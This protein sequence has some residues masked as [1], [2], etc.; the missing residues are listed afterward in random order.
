MDSSRG[1][2]QTSPQG[3][4]KISKIKSPF[5]PQDNPIIAG[6][7]VQTAFEKTQGQINNLAKSQVSLGNWNALTN[8]PTLPLTPTNPTYNS[9]EYYN[10]S[11]SGIFNGVQ[12]T[13][14][15]KIV[16]STN[17]A[18]NTLF[19]ELNNFD[20]ETK[21]DKIFTYTVA[22]LTALY[23][24]TGI[25]NGETAI[26]L[27]TLK[28]YIYTTQWEEVFETLA[29]K[30]QA[31]GYAGLDS[32]TSILASQLDKPI[33]NFLPKI[34]Y[35][36]EI[37]NN[38]AIFDNATNIINKNELLLCTA[39]DGSLPFNKGTLYQI[40]TETASP[41]TAML[42]SF[43]TPV[44]MV[45]KQIIL[46]RNF[47][48][49]PKGNYTAND[50]Q[51]DLENYLNTANP[52]SLI[53]LQENLK[54][55]G[56]VNKNDTTLSWNDANRT[57]TLNIDNSTQIYINGKLYDLP[58]GIFTK[59][60]SNVEGQHYIYFDVDVNNNVIIEE[61]TSFT[62][63]LI[64]KYCIIAY[65]Y[66]D[67]TN[68]KAVLGLQD[69][70]HGMTMDCDTHLY[71]HNTIGTAYQSGLLPSVIAD[72]DGSIDSHIQM[73]GAGGII[74]DEDLKHTIPSRASTDNITVIY[75][76]GANG[77]WVEHSATNK[78]AIPAGTGRAS[79]NQNNLG[80]WQLTE[81]ANNGFGICYAFVCPSID[82]SKK[83]FIILGTD[84]YNNVNDARKA[85]SILPDLGVLPFKEYKL[86]AGFIYK[87]SD[88]YTNSVKSKIV[89][90]DGTTPFIDFRTSTSSQNAPINAN[91]IVNLQNQIDLKQNNIISVANQ[92]EML[93]LTN[94]VVG[95]IVI[96]ADDNNYL[97]RLNAL[98][99]STLSNWEVLGKDAQPVG[100]TVEDVITTNEVITSKVN[101]LYAFTGTPNGGFPAGVT[102]G[103][104]AQKSASVWTVVYTF[105]NAP[106]AIF[107]NSDG[108]TYFKT[109]N[110]ANINTWQAK[111]EPSVYEVGPDK[112]YTTLQSA[113]DAYQSDFT[114]NKLSV[115]VI[116]IY[117]T[118][119]NENVIIGGTTDIQN[120]MIEGYGVQGSSN[121][122]IAKLTIGA[123]AHRVK[124]KNL[125]F[126][127]TTLNAPL[128]IESAGTCTENGVQ[129]VGRGKHFFDNVTL[130]TTNNIS[131]NVTSCDN[132]LNFN[133]C[134][135]GGA[136]K[137]VNIANKSG[138]PTSITI[139]GCANG[140]LN[141]GNNRI[142][143]KNNSL[144]VYRGTISTNG[145]AI[146]DVDISTPIAYSI[147]RAYTA[148]GAPVP[149]VLGSM[150]INDDVGGTLQ[151]LKCTT[152]YTVAGALGVGTPIDL[153]K[154]QVQTDNLKANQSTTYTKTETDA[155]ISSTIASLDVMVF[156]GV[157]DASTNPNYPAGDAGHTYR[158]SVAGKIGGASGINVEIGDIL[159]CLVDGTLSG[160]QAIVGS[161][162]NISQVNIDGAVISN[163][164]ATVDNDFVV[165]SGS[166]GKIIK[167]T[168]L[169]NYK[170][171]LSL[172]KSDV[173]LG[174]VDN[175]SDVNKPVSTATQ[176]ALNLKQNITD[177]ALNTTS[178]TIVGGI[179]ELKI[180]ID[181][182]QN[183]ERR[184]KVF[185]NQATNFTIS[186]SDIDSFEAFEFNQTTTGIIITL[187]APTGSIKK[188]IY[189]KNIGTS[190]INLVDINSPIAIT[191]MSIASFNGTSWNIVAGGGG[192]SV[193]ADTTTTTLN[194][195]IVTAT[196]I[197]NLSALTSLTN[198]PTGIVPITGKLIT[199]ENYYAT[200]GIEQNLLLNDNKY[201]RSYINSIWSSWQLIATVDTTPNSNIIDGLATPPVSP[202]NGDAY[203]MLASPTGAW[204][205]FAQGT[206]ATY[207]ESTVSWVNTIPVN[208]TAITFSNP[209]N[210]SGLNNYYIAGQTYKYNSTWGSPAIAGLLWQL[211]ISSS[212][213]QPYNNQSVSISVA[214][215][216]A[217]VT[218]PNN[219]NLAV[220][221]SVTISSSPNAAFNETV[222][223]TA[224]VS[225]TMF[226]YAKTL[227]NTTTTGTLT[228]TTQLLPSGCTSVLVPSTISFNVIIAVAA[229]SYSSSGSFVCTN[230]R[231][232]PCYV[233]GIPIGK[234]ESI[235]L[236]PNSTSQ[237]QSVDNTTYEIL[238][239]TGHG[240]TNALDR[241]KFIVKL[242]TGNTYVFTDGADENK[243]SYGK[244][245]LNVIDAN[246]ILVGN[247]GKITTFTDHGFITDISY[248]YGN[249]TNGGIGNMADG[250][251]LTT[252]NRATIPLLS[253]IDNRTLDFSP[254]SSFISVNPVP[255]QTQ[256]DSA[257][258]RYVLTDGARTNDVNATNNIITGVGS[259]QLTFS[260]GTKTVY[261]KFAGEIEGLIST[262]ITK[263]AT[264]IPVF[265]A[266]NPTLSI[267][268]VGNNI[269]S[270]ATGDYIIAI[271][272]AKT[273]GDGIFAIPVANFTDA[274]NNVATS[275]TSGKIGFQLNPVVGYRH[276]G[277]ALE[278]YDFIN[279]GLVNWNGTTF[280]SVI[281][282]AFNRKTQYLSTAG[283]TG[284]TINHNL[285]TNS[286]SGEIELLCVTAVA[287][288]TVGRRYSCMQVFN[289]GVW[290]SAKPLSVKTST[291]ARFGIGN[292]NT[293]R[294]D[295][296]FLE[297]SGIMAN[298]KVIAD[299]ESNY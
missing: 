252:G 284:G 27:N 233:A 23:T 46:H 210:L 297:I 110:G 141:I 34:F 66:F 150:I 186:Q 241:N 28:K 127:N 226:K 183:I 207:N 276:N 222:T 260:G 159:I 87:T 75:R 61:T 179:N 289:G 191:K 103:D 250:E 164:T 42:N 270:A 163:E 35:S 45:G 298:F 209:V 36:F 98:P 143:T 253:V 131:L 169:A 171:L 12:Y 245:I 53:T 205:T 26:T 249:P 20:N 200:N 144:S 167:K 132:F 187:T 154:Y 93:A 213:F 60:I 180:G 204:S 296:A 269:N 258:K 77:N 50:T 92:S 291:T 130:S 146:L 203:V 81:I 268:G 63:D 72:G 231:S 158:I 18:T 232:A 4:R 192:F 267:V 202:S 165:F 239:I 261:G 285:G 44:Q 13:D 1:K 128:N 190:S 30:N 16:V 278:Q 116:F 281:N 73:A 133:N 178:K 282:Y 274:V 9:G 299:L 94:K 89:T 174:N 184:T 224:I 134:D 188:D 277:T 208:G 29:N 136:G 55:V 160:N 97:Y 31:N 293:M 257:T 279:M 88:S 62:E 294:D 182:K 292:G 243:V 170:T 238:N 56:F 197:T 41:T 248:T 71:L 262:N 111:S 74:E 273:N 69:E 272:K 51:T 280:T 137:I 223:V 47:N 240:F 40:N 161:N 120:L 275:I 181:L 21:Q 173:G 215:N 99:A 271:N 149:I 100:E 78:I 135:F 58:I 122:Q 6:D 227:A 139:D 25:I 124:L 11:V 68:S 256:V 115:G 33:L 155:K 48:N 166:N 8:T 148:L 5:V 91:D 49:Y 196:G 234:L 108:K 142:I 64:T 76:D 80:V 290:Q 225:P 3:N 54:I 14:G 67:A 79:Y 254:K 216:V 198:G 38:V 151:M 156:K 65:C 264:Q 70:R 107:A 57:A 112:Q 229:G 101:G 230:L 237:W 283:S 219:H 246:N 52:Q 265:N 221:Y 295:G 172:A 266:T 95:D 121:V 217:T 263:L 211:F 235:A 255:V 287:G 177:N 152:A 105:I 17:K 86:V 19:W 59:Q 138:I 123:F 104:I 24:I 244:I 126:S 125:M 228:A 162:W 214:S 43:L 201:F 118:I 175:T 114:S 185:A 199:V 220:G 218:C 189:F 119:I 37:A 82:N 236:L 259:N 90:T 168:T 113:V 117:Q 194:L 2:V 22:N 83:W 247:G 15:D 212:Q 85:A 39:S 106:A 109:I 32:D 242:Q 147:L 176:T 96:R 129:N 7:T 84:S 10:V 193:I 195:N 145:T 140:L 286:F 102:Q 251:T 153:T 157:I 206:V 288:F